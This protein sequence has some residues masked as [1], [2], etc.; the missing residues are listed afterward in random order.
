M[1]KVSEAKE[2]SKEIVC[3]YFNEFLS[4]TYKNATTVS[5]ET[6]LNVQRLFKIRKGELCPSIDLL[7]IL[8]KYYKLNANFFLGLSNKLFLEGIEENHDNKI[9]CEDIKKENE[10]LKETI[11]ILNQ[12]VTE[13]DKLI[14]LYEEKNK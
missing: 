10:M 6:G 1:S 14:S 12:V 3:K 9:L 2:L 5:K 4:K 7:L 11:A 13:K 8:C